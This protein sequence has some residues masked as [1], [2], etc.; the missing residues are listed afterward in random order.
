MSQAIRPFT[1]HVDQAAIDD[2]HQRLERVI[3]PN[4]LPGVGDAYGVTNERVMEL[5]AY[6]RD[7][8]DWRAFEAKLN[9]YPQFVTEMADDEQALRAFVEAN[10]LR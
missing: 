6:W 1:V 4:A 9:A 10:A 5:A 8:F 3:W 7:E 2:L